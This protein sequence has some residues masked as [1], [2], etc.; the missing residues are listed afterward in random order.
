M[1]VD[2]D[3]R[4]VLCV[5]AALFLFAEAVGAP[6]LIQRVGYGWTGLVL[7]VLSFLV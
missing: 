5:V 2:A 3:L 4:V 6:R 1:K 7:F